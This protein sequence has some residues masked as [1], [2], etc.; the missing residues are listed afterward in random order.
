MEATLEGS[1]PGA[2][3]AAILLMSRARQLG[4]PL[5]VH[6]AGNPDDIS[7]VYGPA[8]V[9]SPVL[10]SC[11]VGRSFGHGGTVVIPGLDD[12]PLMVS[13]QTGGT[14]QWFEISRSGPG[15]NE[16]TQAFYRMSRDPRVEVRKLAK[17]IRQTFEALGLAPKTGFLDFLF[18]A[19]IPPLTRIALTLRAGR[20]VHT[21]V[22]Q[23]VTQF[24][25]GQGPLSTDEENAFKPEQVSGFLKSVIERPSWMGLHKEATAHVVQWCELALTAATEDNG[26]DGA[27]IYELAELIQHLAQLPAHSILPPLDSTLDGVALCL[28]KALGAVGNEDANQSLRQMFTFLGGRYVAPGPNMHQVYAID[29][30]EQPLARWQWFC[31]AAMEGRRRADELWPLITDPPS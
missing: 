11:G 2:T 20:S 13:L 26:R 4:Y 28:P 14:S 29:A 10:A 6:I 19:P 17:Q 15:H 25:S 21:G 9:H 27:L 18:C 23:P 3:T 7:P 1:S 12:A 5:R 24:F 30:P 22:S 8:V 16:G 31:E